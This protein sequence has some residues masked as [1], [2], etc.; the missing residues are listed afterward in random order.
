MFDIIG[1]I[2]GHADKLEE[3]LLKLGY[4]CNNEIYAH[5]SRRVLF[6]G[7]YIDRGPQIR[8]T[9]G[10]V[11][12]MVEHGEAIALMGNHEYNALCFHRQETE[13]GHLRRHLIKNIVQHYETL[14]Q[15]LNRQEEYEDYLEWFKTLPLFFEND[16]FRVV[17][18]TWDA[19]LIEYMRQ[20]LVG[21]CLT[22]ELIYKSV[23]IGTPLNRAVEDTLKGRAI[24]M[25]DGLTFKDKD[26]TIRKDM[27]VK[28]WIN[29]LTSTYREFSITPVK[30]LPD[31][32]VDPSVLKCTNYYP[33]DERPVFFGHYW[34]KGPPTLYRD[35]V[36]CL[37]YS[38]AR[39]GNLV[40]YR[41]DG[42]PQ[43]RMDKLVFV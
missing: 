6:L 34:L 19:R 17:H 10:L 28:W 22:D 14:R 3:L 41:M 5:T 8:E 25:P 7:D 38:V 12:A 27:R 11:R 24:P 42:E 37:D 32:P 33:K 30:C 35:N 2:H 21:G 29:P 26:G 31:R 15:F 1:D 9:L 20:H 23:K 13:G 16:C 18:A 4:T 36:C 40:A 43:L 39:E